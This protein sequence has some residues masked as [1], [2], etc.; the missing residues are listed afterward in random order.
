[1][2]DTVQ[3]VRLRGR[4]INFLIWGGR[5]IDVYDGPRSPDAA[6]VERLDAIKG[7]PEGINEDGTTLRVGAGGMIV[8]MAYLVTVASDARRAAVRFEQL[9]AGSAFFPEM[10]RATLR[11]ALDLPSVGGDT[12]YFKRIASEQIASWPA[13]TAWVSG[14]GD[15]C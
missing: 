8:I 10:H 3:H 13:G 12:G 2:T 5:V 4:R 15:S 9:F 11:A 14:L 1:M 6:I 7:G